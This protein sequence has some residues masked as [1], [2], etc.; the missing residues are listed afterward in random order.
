MTIPELYV[1]AV[2][3][4]ALGLIITETLRADLVALLVLLALAAG[5]VVK[6][7]EAL[8]G[9]SRSAVITI[10][11]LFV[12]TAALDRTG[13]TRAM[14]DHLLRIGGGSE[15]RMVFLFMTGA[16]ILSLF[17][18]NIAAGAVLLPAAVNVSRRTQIPASKLLMPLS[19]GSL[20]GGMATF[21]TTAN[22]LVS[23]TLRDQGLKPL[24]VLDFTPT[25]GI[26]AVAGI[27]YMIVI[28]RRLLP[29]RTPVEQFAAPNR[30]SKDLETV[31]ALQE[32][33]WEA[34]VLP[35][36]PLAGKTLGESGIGERLGLTVIGIWHNDDANLIPTPDD[37]IEEGDILLIA[38]REDRV[39]Q[40]VAQGLKIGRGTNGRSG[41]SGFTS[42]GGVNGRGVALIEAVIAPHSQVEG[43]TLKDLNFRKKYGL[44][45]I[46]LWREGRS[47]RTDVGNFPL[48]FGDALLMV[49]PPDRA[50]V[51]RAEPDFLVLGGDI[52]IEPPRRRAVTAIAITIFVL[53]IAALNLVPVAESMLLGTVL[54]VLTRCLTMDEAYRSVEWRAIFLIAGML[55][56]SIAMNNTGLATDLGNALVK[57]LGPHGPLAVIGGLYALT[58]LLTQVMSGQ[59]TALVLAPIAISAA[60]QMGTS[61]QAAG[62][63]VAIGCST[64][65]LT[66]IA[67]PVNV[68]VM[69]PGGYTF[70][71]FFK[72]GWGLTVVCFVA[73]LIVLPLFWRL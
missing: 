13:V 38:G 37:V 4:I 27:I 2:I 55:P 57:A 24:G 32:R 22:I 39:S 51:L 10:L 1:T 40:L 70:G 56:I 21:F 60:L 61:P 11:G 28:G 71:D 41:I 17:M 47:Y 23:T 63:A 3:V 31:Y 8:S 18:N 62:L 20:L 66:P 33:L 30:P 52:D 54:M 26:V 14:A 50:K 69:G 12:I 19:V 16:A 6:P 53:A 64:S 59:V 15:A 9:F 35:N 73:V 44:T 5:G 65:F 43:R 7:E 45:A 36:S 42:I 72:V 29:V 58:V 48:R 46:A 68:L 25:G 67:H 49:G 34:E